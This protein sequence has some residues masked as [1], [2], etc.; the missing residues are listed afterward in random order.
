MVPT[1]LD[2]IV[3]DSRERIARLRRQLQNPADFDHLVRMVIEES[4]A[5]YDPKARAFALK[6]IF[7]KD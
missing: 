3:R 1:S 7:G 2:R 5:G 6:A 4:L